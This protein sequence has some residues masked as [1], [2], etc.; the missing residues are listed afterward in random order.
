MTLIKTTDVTN[1]E[2]DDVVI[3]LYEPRESTD[4]VKPDLKYSPRSPLRYPGGKNR[5]IREICAFIPTS[6][7]ILC[8]PF[9]GGGSV[10]LTCT[11]RME[12]RGYDIFSPLVDF[13]NILLQDA[14][15]LADKVTSYYPLSKERFYNLQKKYLNL[16]NTLERAAAFYVLNRSSF[17]GTTLSGGMS[18]NHPRFT[19]SAIE[20]LR[21]FKIHNLKVEKADFQD[22]IINN[23]NAFLYLDPPYLNGQNLYGIN[24]PRPYGRGFNLFQTSFAQYLFSLVLLCT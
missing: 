20:R 4:L 22:S 11:V 3:K 10:E 1:I 17:S 24:F 16:D 6:E 19:L 12:V 14:N 18:P 15:L 8:S 9:I 2:L 13:W 5:A 7:K 21:Q 23:P